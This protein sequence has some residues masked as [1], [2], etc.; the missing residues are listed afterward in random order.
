VRLRSLLLALV[1]SLPAASA[2]ADV[3]G[4]L[5]PE[6]SQICGGSAHAPNCRSEDVGMA[7]CGLGVLVLVAG[8]ALLAMRGRREK[9]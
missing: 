7:C 9:Q 8:G 4:M 2:S 6:L 1:L 5:D 3:V